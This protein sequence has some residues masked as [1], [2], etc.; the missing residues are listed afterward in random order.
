M[1]VVIELAV[2]AAAVWPLVRLCTTP[3]FIRKLRSFPAKALGLA[4]C[5]VAGIASVVI[6][7]VA[8]PEMLRAIAVLAGI[9]VLALAWRARPAYGR[10]RGLPPG[11]LGALPVGPRH[12]GKVS[13][14][15]AERG[16]QESLHIRR[17]GSS[18]SPV[19]RK[20]LRRW[21]AERV[22]SHRGT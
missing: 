11:S 4:A 1:E 20:V 2:I 3:P 12:Q 22:P 8:Y 13:S 19:A 6:V 18:V 17:V 15:G 9:V 16:D 21:I 14:D 7:T 5:W 10:T